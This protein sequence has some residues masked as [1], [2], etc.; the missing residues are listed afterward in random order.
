MARALGLYDL[1][2]IA[3]TSMFSQSSIHLFISS[4]ISALA[5]NTG[6]PIDPEAME[7]A[8]SFSVKAQNSQTGAEDGATP[9]G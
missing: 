3:V 8:R 9:K 6:N 5:P 2:F 4:F 1:K 7:V